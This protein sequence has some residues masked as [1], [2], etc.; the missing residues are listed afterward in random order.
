MRLSLSESC[1]IPGVLVAEYVFRDNLLKAPVGFGLSRW[2]FI[3]GFF[4]RADEAGD[5]SGSRA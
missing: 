4:V 5:A 3:D 2:A 1:T